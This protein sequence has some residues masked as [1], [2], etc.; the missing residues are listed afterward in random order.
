MVENWQ[1]PVSWEKDGASITGVSSVKKGAWTSILKATE[2]HNGKTTEVIIKTFAVPEHVLEDPERIAKER[3]KFLAAA[4]L[5]MELNKA[6]CRGWVK[7]LRLS[8]D[9]Q[10][11][12]FSMEKCGPS[13]QDLIDNKAPVSAKELYDLVHSV[14]Q[15]LIELKERHKRSHGSIK[16]S[17]VLSSGQGGSPAFKLADPAARGEDHSANDLYALGLVLYELIEGREWDPLNPIT[18]TRPW[19]RLGSK[20]DKWIQFVTMLLNPNGCHEPLADVKREAYRLKPS[21]PVKYA[22]LGAGAVVLI[23][24]GAVGYHFLVRGAIKGTTPVVENK[25][26]GGGPE[27]KSSG[28]VIASNNNNNNTGNAGVTVD[29]EARAAYDAA[30]QA[31]QEALARWSN[32]QT[33]QRYDHAGSIGIA[34]QARSMAPDGLALTTGEAFRSGAE[35]Y[36][37]AA[38]KFDEAV[39][40]AAKEEEVGQGQDAAVFADLQKAQAEYAQAK[41]KW[42]EA[43]SRFTPNR[44]HAPSMALAKAAVIEKLETPTDPA[45]ARHAAQEYRTSAGRLADAVAMAAKEELSGASQDEVRTAFEEARR[46]YNT[47]R[48]Q[49]TV[50]ETAAAKEEGI[51]LAAARAA[52]E[53]ARKMLPDQVVLSDLNS[54]R[55][56]AELY[57]KASARLKDALDQVE[58]QRSEVSLRKGNVAEAV[59]KANAALEA[60]DYE[61]ALDW[62]KRAAE[63]GNASAMR[64]VGL[65]YETGQGTAK[66]LTQAAAWYKRAAEKGQPNAA[67]DLAYLYETGRGV[68][69]D[70]NA[71]AEWYKKAAAAKNPE[72]MNRLGYFYENGWGVPQDYAEA[73]KWY[74]AG[75][76]LE[77]ATAMTNIGV[78]YD[79]GR[80]VQQDPAEAMK[81]YTRA[82]DK[83]SAAAMND[84]GLLYD[85]GRGVR[86]NYTEAMK[87]Y[88]RAAE[89]NYGPAMSNIG[90]LYDNGL[91]VKA[92]PAEAVNWFRKGAALNHGMSMFNLAFMYERGR[93]V[94]ADIVQAVQWYR[95][96]VK[97]ND[98]AAVQAAKEALDRLGYAHEG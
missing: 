90:V 65:L 9:P 97:S 26:G 78:L 58:K 32:R 93:G 38:A 29:A 20:R 77:D 51:D 3:E 94:K 43:V 47:F 24:A 21:S 5:Q 74:Q 19:S 46:V 16:A 17:D 49:W 13:V 45:E 59:T 73:M 28:G 30:R 68:E 6:G 76:K 10:N 14:L 54:Y 79:K 91:G 50:T 56:T 2:T 35:A 64:N 87:W 8:E 57:V 81:W 12:S 69:R 61:T 18:P 4:K 85:T 42:D 72:A 33:T 37:K 41:Q 52:A 96:A 40:Q 15:A 88:L 34:R 7:I 44:D 36:R 80:G 60:K 27:T 70:Y 63:M 11:P 22:V 92:D 95:R 71:A 31:Y 86:T 39:A 75:A 84:V 25:N 62:Y 55:R 23:V 82:A 89:K 53:D 1:S 48:E 98:P 66:D 83:G 67:Y